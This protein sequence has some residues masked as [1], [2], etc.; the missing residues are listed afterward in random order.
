VIGLRRHPLI[1][2]IFSRSLPG[3]ALARAREPPPRTPEIPGSQPLFL[4]IQ[5]FEKYPANAVCCKV[6]NLISQVGSL[7]GNSALA[8]AY[9]VI[10]ARLDPFLWVLAQNGDAA[11][12]APQGNCFI[13]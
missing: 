8:E 6:L 10:V 11:S 5:L 9:R 2:P 3:L 13:P 12:R 7:P 4:S 1:N